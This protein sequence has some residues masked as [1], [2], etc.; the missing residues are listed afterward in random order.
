MYKK[1]KTFDKKAV[2]DAF[3]LKIQSYILRLII[4]LVRYNITYSIPKNAHI[5]VFMYLIRSTF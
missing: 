2:F 3:L 1:P 5:F 4:K